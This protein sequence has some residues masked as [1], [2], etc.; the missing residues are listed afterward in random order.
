[1]TIDPRSLFCIIGVAVRIALRMGL[2]TDGTNYAIPPFEVELRRRLWYQI[3]LIDVRVAELSGCG[4]SILTYGWTTKLPSNINDS[5][6][7]P[8]MRDPPVERPGI[9]EM[10]FVRLRCEGVQLVQQLRE[11]SLAFTGAK[12]DVIIEFGQRLEQDYLSHCDPLIPLH[13]MSIMMTRSMICK[14]RMG[15]RH[16]HS[17]SS[18]NSDL[19]EAEKDALFQLAYV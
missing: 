19:S 12:E 14:L 2:G 16:P 10:I 1:M 6:L 9:T 15:L 4:T 17:M 18:R 8:D 13:V 5:D 11:P 7:F 3:V